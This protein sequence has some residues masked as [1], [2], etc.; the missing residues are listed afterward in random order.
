MWKNYVP[1]ALASGSLQLKPDANVVGH[2]LDKIQDA[3]DVLRKG[4][5]AQKVVVTL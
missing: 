1:A 5:S 4:V 3:L 2:G